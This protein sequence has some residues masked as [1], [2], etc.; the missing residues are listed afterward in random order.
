MARRSC[1]STPEMTPPKDRPGLRSGVGIAYFRD[2][3]TVFF[4]V[5]KKRSEFRSQKS[6]DRN[7]ETGREFWRRQNKLGAVE[8]RLEDR[9][10]P[11]RTQTN[12]KSSKRKKKQFTSNG[13][14]KSLQVSS[15]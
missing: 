5:T 10:V 12:R 11:Q 8:A 7:R 4:S 1:K 6:V 3:G 2:E 9:I 14:N 13:P 15:G